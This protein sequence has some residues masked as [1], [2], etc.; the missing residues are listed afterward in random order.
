MMIFLSEH[1]KDK[2]RLALYAAYK[3]ERV[4]FTNEAKK[5]HLVFKSLKKVRANLVE[6]CSANNY[7]CCKT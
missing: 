3:S 1:S 7:E 5:L 6:K 4:K 2:K